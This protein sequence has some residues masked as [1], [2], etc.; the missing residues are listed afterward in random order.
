MDDV[1]NLLL[2]AL[3]QAEHALSTDLS[4]E[5]GCSLYFAAYVAATKA[6]PTTITKHGAHQ[7]TCDDRGI[8]PL[9]GT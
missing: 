4:T 2:S 8:E 7:R 5:A 3:M 9:A 1:K 6:W